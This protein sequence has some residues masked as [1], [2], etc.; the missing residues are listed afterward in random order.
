[1][2][3]TTKKKAGKGLNYFGLIFV[4]VG[5]GFGIFM[6]GGAALNYLEA[7]DW[8]PVQATVLA[9]DLHVSRSDDGT[10]YRVDATYRYRFDGRDYTGTRV[11]VHGG[12]DNI[13]DYHQRWHSK[14]AHAQRNNHH[15]TA[16]VNPADPTEALLDRELRWPLMGFMSIFAIVFAGAG[17]FFTF[18]GRLAQRKAGQ[19]L[20]GRPVIREKGLAQV[21]VFGFMTAMFTLIPLPGVLAIPE[22]IGKG[23]LAILVVLLFPLAA[24]WLGYMTVKGYLGWK[25]FG[26]VEVRLDPHP[27][28]VG[29]AVAGTIKL[30]GRLASREQVDVQLLCKHVRIRRSGKSTSRSETVLWE[31][32]QT[33]T[34]MA[35]GRGTQLEF[36]FDTPPDLPPSDEPD[37]DYHEWELHLTAEVPGVDL[38]RRVTIPVEQN[39]NPRPSHIRAAPELES[40]HADI[41]I[42][43][44]VVG[45]ETRGDSH[46]FAYPSSRLRGMGVAL[47]VFG[48]VFFVPVVFLGRGIVEDPSDWFA[49]AGGLFGLVFGLVGLGLFLAGV[50]IAGN[51]LEV[52]V[53]NGEITSRRTLLGLSRARRGFVDDVEEIRIKQGGSSTVGG[54]RTV[55]YQLHALSR[56]GRK[57]PLGDGIP[58]SH[59]AEHIKQRLE[60]AIGLTT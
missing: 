53:H 4:A 38:D 29:G 11:S 42:P 43:A 59:L 45:I 10:T 36:R 46:R 35:V 57:I 27:G 24:L 40:V 19:D 14:L 23:N 18:I 39:E 8:V 28:Q 44:K 50:Y 22:E 60:A 1:M 41:E 7:R 3:T 20:H 33:L 21:Y 47:L 9:T 55:Y 34:P 17:L 37:R 52:I 51:S 26:V 13:G 54:R 25:R 2:K 5:L 31:R 58:G 30:E 12:S 15:L 16:W 49:W 32:T 56:N 6:I 48:V